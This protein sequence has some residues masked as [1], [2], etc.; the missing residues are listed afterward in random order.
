LFYISKV[1][2]IMID[3]AVKFSSDGKI[4][5]EIREAP[6]SKF[7]SLFKCSISDPGIGI[8][9]AMHEKIF[10][11]FVQVDSSKTRKFEGIGLGLAIAR[12]MVELMGG[13]TGVQSDEGKGSSFN[14]SFHCQ[15]QAR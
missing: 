3:N 12:R 2:A 7:T 9:A 6:L 4:G 10:E 1:F 14:F 11:P 15:L 13:I 5:I 8:P